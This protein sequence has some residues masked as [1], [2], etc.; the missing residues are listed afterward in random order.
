LGKKLASI[1][2]SAVKRKFSPEFI[3]RIDAIVTY[4][5]LDAPSL[6]AIVDQQIMELEQHIENRLGDDAFELDVSAEARAWLLRKGTS[7][8]YG[9]RELKRVLLRHLTQPLAAMVAAGEIQPEDLVRVDAGDSGLEI[10][11]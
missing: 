3:N 11:I 10:N 5:P 7:D 6:E 4:Q 9:A 8:E 1:G 2:T